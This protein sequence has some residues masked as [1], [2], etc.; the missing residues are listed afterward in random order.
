LGRCKLWKDAADSGKHKDDTSQFCLH[1]S[2]P[3]YYLFYRTNS[4]FCKDEEMVQ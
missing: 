4:G 3:S 2:T 1:G